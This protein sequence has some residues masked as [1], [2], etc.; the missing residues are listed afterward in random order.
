MF[1]LKKNLPLCKEAFNY[2]G[3]QM[4]LFFLALARYLGCEI[5]LPAIN[6]IYQDDAREVA[7]HLLSGKEEWIFGG[8]KNICI[9]NVD[10]STSP[11][12]QFLRL[13][14]EFEKFEEL[15]PYF[16]SLTSA[17]ELV[18][19][20]ECEYEP[21]FSLLQ[22]EDIEDEEE[23]EIAQDMYDAIMDALEYMI[24]GDS[25]MRFELSNHLVET[26]ITQ[27]CD[28]FYANGLYSEDWYDA[29][30][31]ICPYWSKLFEF[32][33]TEN[34]LYNKHA[35]EILDACIKYLEKASDDSILGKGNEYRKSGVCFFTS[36]LHIEE[37][38]LIIGWMVNKSSE[39]IEE[40]DRNTA[41]HFSLVINILLFTAREIYKKMM[42]TKKEEMTDVA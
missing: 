15:W 29:D 27:L 5:E 3:V 2:S 7:S 11:Y 23:E 17:F 18:S 32:L 37:G 33:D 21:L 39:D 9:N 20:R 38:S 25:S 13:N 41:S 34:S 6:T 10:S 35:R 1:P 42:E 22:G 4:K 36:F 19:W 24:L 16:G 8:F 30:L 40:T 14:S 26:S 31:A 28:M 12:S